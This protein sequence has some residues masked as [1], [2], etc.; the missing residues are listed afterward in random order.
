MHDFRI[1][2]DDPIVEHLTR[3]STF[4]VGQRVID[5]GFASTWEFA[6]DSLFSQRLFTFFDAVAHEVRT[7]HGID[8]WAE[9]GDSPGSYPYIE[10]P[11]GDDEHG[12]YIGLWFAEMADYSTR[13][14]ECAHTGRYYDGHERVFDVP[15]ENVCFTFGSAVDALVTAHQHVTAALAAAPARG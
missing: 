13:W 15:H 3:L 5:E 6:T 4:Y 2:H 12:E 1:R 8:C 11:A 9:T 14:L 10:M 7:K